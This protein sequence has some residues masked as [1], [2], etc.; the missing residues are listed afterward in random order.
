MLTGEDGENPNTSLGN[1]SLGNIGAFLADSVKN[2]YHAVNTPEA[3]NVAAAEGEGDLPSS[4]SKS[5]FDTTEKEE[6]ELAE[7]ET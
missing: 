7:S 6:K 5:K 2:A 1:I 4:E 3:S